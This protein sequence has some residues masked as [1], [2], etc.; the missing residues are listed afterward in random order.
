MV[1]P[2]LMQDV[3]IRERAR[4]HVCQKV[5]HFIWIQVAIVIAIQ[6]LKFFLSL[7]WGC[8][9]PRGAVSLGVR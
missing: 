4:I 3:V 6:L 1:W 7:R 5:G 2:Y 9:E 8:G